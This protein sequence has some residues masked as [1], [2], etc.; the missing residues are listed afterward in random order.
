MNGAKRALTASRLA[1]STGSSLRRS[2][3]RR[4]FF[5][6]RINLLTRRQRRWHR[7]RQ[8]E[9]SMS[10]IA[11]SRS[12][13][14]DHPDT[15]VS[16]KRRHAMAKKRPMMTV[17]QYLRTQFEGSDREYLDGRIVERNMGEWCHGT[18]QAD[19]AHLLGLK[20][21]ALGIQVVSEIRMRVAETRIRIPDVAVWLADYEPEGVP[22]VPPFL[23]VEVISPDDRPKPMQAKV[24]EYIAWGV[25][26]VWLINPYK[27]TARSYS[28]D[29]APDGE[30]VETRL[31]TENPI[32]ELP[33]TELFAG[34]PKKRTVPEDE[35][36]D[37]N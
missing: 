32:I 2:S 13:H 19:V 28:E 3:E 15:M 18:V 35:A 16:S 20:Q 29:N 9:V 22:T 36:P 34:L 4:F 5:T 25:K 6:P 30:M 8:R 23:A 37:W 11:Q 31:R 21:A 17:E 12:I 14:T 10:S 33:F 24:E 7:R 26:W 27:K 1:A